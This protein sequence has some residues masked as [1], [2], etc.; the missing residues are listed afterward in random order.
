MINIITL[1]KEFFISP[2]TVN[3]I[4]ILSKLLYS[5]AHRFRLSIVLIQL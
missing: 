5:L 2:N 4:T 3:V 1:L